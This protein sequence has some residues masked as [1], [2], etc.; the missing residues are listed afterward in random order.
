MLRLRG[1]VLSGQFCSVSYIVGTAL[2][3]LMF[4]SDYWRQVGNGVGF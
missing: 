2:V 3:V 4:T 1:R